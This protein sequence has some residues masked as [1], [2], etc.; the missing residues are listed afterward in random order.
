MNSDPHES[1]AWRAFGMLDADEAAGFDEAMRQ[2]PELGKIYREM[3]CLT[4]A[5]AAATVSPLTPRAGQLERLQTRL[6]LNASKHT[7][8]LGISGWAAAAALTMVL[9]LDRH[10][11]SATT[12]VRHI[13]PSLPAAENHAEK[14]SS[15]KSIDVD[16][17][18]IAKDSTPAN[19]PENGALLATQE[20][21]VRTIVKG[22]TKRL[23]QEIEV[24]RGKLENAQTRD[25]KRF[26]AVP[27]VSWPVVMTMSPPGAAASKEPSEVAAV[28]AHP[29]LVTLLGD[30]LAGTSTIMDASNAF[31][32][33][34]PTTVFG[35][36]SAIPIYDAARD[37]GTLVVSNLPPTAP[38]KPYNLWVKTEDGAKPIY[39]GRLPDSI[40][41]A[42]TSY[43]FSL[44]SNGIV[45][46][47]FILTQD[48]QGETAPPSER[49][50]ILLGPSP[51]TK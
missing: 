21:D 32:A 31:R 43:D 46:T 29:P 12:S 48:A 19:P 38:E 51:V 15:R 22:E 30:A 7:N 26:E 27:G 25:R 47:S 45:P 4:A 2:D 42:A 8:W 18:E 17:R 10:P 6:G 33:A 35:N 28:A 9:I 5:V 13:S 20:N 36:P 23:I 41:E 34:N 16:E 11:S 49:N 3:N 1:A 44:G 14:I 37:S 24:L 50:T 39:V 40:S